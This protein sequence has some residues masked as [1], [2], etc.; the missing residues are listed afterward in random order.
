MCNGVA[1]SI[2]FLIITRMIITFKVIQLELKYLRVSDGQ[3]DGKKSYIFDLQLCILNKHN[4]RS[5]CG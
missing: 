5:V 1:E 2:S 3:R 4:V